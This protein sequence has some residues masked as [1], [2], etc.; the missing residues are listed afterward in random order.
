MSRELESRSTTTRTERAELTRRMSPPR[1]KETQEQP[2][3][4][5]RKHKKVVKRKVKKIV[6]KTD[7]S[8]KPIDKKGNEAIVKKIADILNE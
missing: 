5:P 2:I 3:E 1:H 8:A 7:E 4:K 6:N